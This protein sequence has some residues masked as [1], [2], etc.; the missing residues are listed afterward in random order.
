MPLELQDIRVGYGEDTV[1]W[2]DHLYFED[3]SITALMGPSG[4]GKSTL[5]RSLSGLNE[6]VPGSWQTGIIKERGNLIDSPVNFLGYLPQKARLF[7]ETVEESLLLPLGSIDSSHKL[8]PDEMRNQLKKLKLWPQ[9]TERLSMPV[10]DL[11]LADHKIILIARL[12]ASGYPYLLLDEPFL[13][14]AIADEPKIVDFIRLLSTIGKTI[15]IVL[16]NKLI[17]RSL[18]THVALLSGGRLIEANTTAQFFDSPQNEMTKEFMLSGSSWPHT[19][20]NLNGTGEHIKNKPKD[21]P[22]QAKGMSIILSKTLEFHWVLPAL[23]GGMQKPGIGREIGIDLNILREQQVKHLISLTQA[24]I[25][26]KMLN[27]YSI[28][29]IHFPI[30]DMQAPE[31]FAA[32]TLCRTVQQLIQQRQTVIFHCRAGL[33]R[34]GTMLAATIMCMNFSA[35][36]AIERIRFVN[37]RYIQSS[38]Q[39]AFLH[40]FEH[41]IE[42]DV[43]QLSDMNNSII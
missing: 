12:A 7:S 4:V 1:L 35:V 18:S 28:N 6:M 39:I 3:N 23:L 20:H 36:E 30:D 2:V 29:G 42:A 9:F 24:T 26:Q 13:D 27:K 21:K 10:S 25:D 11:P 38:P 17:A 40:A 19:D 22:S 32:L 15:I 37:P 16:H 33:G 8:S 31:M 34:T 5:L 14:V 43:T 41:Y